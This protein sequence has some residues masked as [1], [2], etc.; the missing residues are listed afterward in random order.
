MLFCAASPER[1]RPS[2]ACHPLGACQPLFAEHWHR[3]SVVRLP[4]GRV[5]MSLYIPRVAARARLL[6]LSWVSSFHGAFVCLFLRPW[7]SPTRNATTPIILLP[8]LPGPLTFGLAC[9]SSLHK[10]LCHLHSTVPLHCRCH[11]FLDGPLKAVE[12]ITAARRFHHHLHHSSIS[13]LC[14]P[15]RNMWGYRQSCPVWER[16]SF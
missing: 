11:A 4:V 15:V 1:Q 2:S 5:A 10:R 3:Q 13:S 16:V 12:A 6:L 7:V 8:S 14:T 9:I